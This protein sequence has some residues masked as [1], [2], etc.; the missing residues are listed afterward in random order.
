MSKSKIEKQIIENVAKTCIDSMHKEKHLPILHEFY[1]FHKVI[2]FPQ[3][4]KDLISL[5]QMDVFGISKEM[6]IILKN[7]N[8]LQ[9]LGNIVDIKKAY[10][11]EYEKLHN[12]VV[13]LVK[14][15]VDAKDTISS[16]ANEIMEKFQEN[17]YDFVFQKTDYA[18][19][20]IIYNGSIV[21]YTSS[22]VV[23]NL[24]S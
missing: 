14:V 19:I 2:N 1:G 9:L 15:G 22:F 7:I 4:I 11:K 3:T 16:I 17:H 20:S 18:G 23:K 13:V 6:Q 8:K 24:Q 21:E 5:D 12:K 10:Q